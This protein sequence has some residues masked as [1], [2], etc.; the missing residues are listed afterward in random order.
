MTRTIQ[1]VRISLV[2]LALGAGVGGHAL[3]DDI[4][5]PGDYFTI[6]AAVVNASDGDRIILAGQTYFENLVVNKDLEFVGLGA[7]QTRLHGQNIGT[8]MTLTNGAQ[9][10]LRDL[11]V[12]FG[13]ALDGGGLY[14]NSGTIATVEDCV[15]ENNTADD[16]G[17]AVQVNGTLIA[18]RTEF[19]LNSLDPATG[20][21]GGAIFADSAVVVLEDCDFVQ[22]TSRGSGGGVTFF[23]GTSIDLDRCVFS[24][25]ATGSGGSA[26]ALYA[27][28]GTSGTVTDTDF[29]SNTAGSNGGAVYHDEAPVRYERCEFLDN[30]TGG[31]NGND[32]GAVWATGETT[33]EM[34]FVNCL[35]ARNVAASSGGALYLST[36]TDAKVLNCTIIDNQSLGVTG[37]AADGGAIFT[38]GTNAG[39]FIRNCLVRGNTPNQFDADGNGV[40]Y[41]NVQGGWPG[42]GNVDLPVTLA[43]RAGGDYR[44]VEGSFSIDAGNTSLWANTGTGI[45]NPTDDNPVDLDGNPRVLN[46]A[47]TSDTG[48]N[49]LGLAVDHGC[50]EF[51]PEPAP[52]CPAD[53]NNDGILDN[54]DIGAFVQLFLAGCP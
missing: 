49:T 1:S 22:N 39:T 23:N 32:G 51:Q 33:A 52:E 45:V 29:L 9:V 35:F 18:R 13:S 20:G 36:G 40:E 26:G 8:V 14:V 41:S 38:T 21:E 24:G 17:G 54:G 47:G 5:V 11:T 46:D 10:T 15:F 25:N 53:I 7:G 6:A 31:P 34:E 2:G 30:S 12:E 48:R 16:D 43:D 27:R 42:A 4:S 28:P 44:L 50:Y 19:T 3:G 37:G